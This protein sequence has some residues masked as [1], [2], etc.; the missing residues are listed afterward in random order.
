MDLKLHNRDVIPK[1]IWEL[2]IR[3]PCQEMVKRV[4]GGRKIGGI[5]KI[6]YKT[7]LS[8]SFWKF[9]KY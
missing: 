3:R 2:Y 9:Q 5:Y 1:L 6:T 8:K 7:L 4:T